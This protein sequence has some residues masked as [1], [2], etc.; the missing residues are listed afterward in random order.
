MDKEKE[1]GTD[2]L[3]ES[4]V[5]A[6]HFHLPTTVFHTHTELFNE[7]GDL[8]SSLLFS[9]IALSTSSILLP[10]TSINELHDTGWVG[11]IAATDSSQRQDRIHLSIELRVKAFDGHAIMKVVAVLWDW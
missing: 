3:G 1:H 7:F 5:F 10:R 11:S 8:L 9:F 4:M 2:S 6:L